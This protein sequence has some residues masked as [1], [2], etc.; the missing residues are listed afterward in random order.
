MTSDIYEHI[1]NLIETMLFCEYYKWYRSSTQS[2][3]VEISRKWTISADP[4]ADPLKICQNCL[5]KES[6]HTRKL[7][8][9]TSLYTVEAT[10]AVIYLWLLFFAGLNFSLKYVS[11][12]SLN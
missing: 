4:W 11:Y 12:D 6:L 7:E 5:P 9:I 8:E 1:L 3:S 10:L 2:P